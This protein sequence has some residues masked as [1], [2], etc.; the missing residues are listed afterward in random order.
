[1][2]QRAP[3]DALG[4]GIAGNDAGIPVAQDDAFGHRG[5]DRAIARLALDQC[6]LGLLAF[7]DV[8]DV[9]DQ[10]RDAAIGM[11]QRGFI[12]NRVVILP[13]RGGDGGLV[14]LGSG[15]KPQRLVVRVQALG[16]FPVIG[17]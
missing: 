13:V 10:T 1:M 16:N 4:A 17:V 9:A 11:R 14:R 8:D 6:L 7:G 2:R 12:V 3:E 5:D 15:S